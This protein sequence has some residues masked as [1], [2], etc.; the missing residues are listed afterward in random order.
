MNGCGRVG[1]WVN[2]CADEWGNGC[3]DDRL[4]GFMVVR[5][6]GCTNEYTGLHPVLGYFAP[7]WLVGLVYNADNLDINPQ[8]F[9]HS[10]LPFLT[11]F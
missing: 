5:I 10:W 11:R 6:H 9:L 8:K 1:E 3:A 7:S 2:D 4:Y